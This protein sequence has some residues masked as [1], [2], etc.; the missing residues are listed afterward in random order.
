MIVYAVN[1]HTGGGKVL[2]DALIVDQPFG[3]ITK[4]YA[5]SRYVAP[6][7]KPAGVEVVAVKPTLYNRFFAEIK[8]YKDQGYSQA[9]EILFFGNLPPLFRPFFGLNKNKKFILYL[10]NAFLILSFSYPKNSF[11]ELV[12][13]SV[14]KLWLHLF[15]FNINEI[16]VQTPWMKAQT[17]LSLG[18]D[19]TIKVAPFLP[20]LPVTEKSTVKKYKFLYVGSLAKHKGLET[21]LKALQELDKKITTKISVCVVLDSASQNVDLGHFKNID[22]KLFTSANREDL[23]NIY[24]DSEYLVCTSRLESFYLPIYEAHHFGCAIILPANASYSANLPA[25]INAKTYTAPNLD[26]I[27]F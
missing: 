15:N 22:I 17:L 5:D 4:V 13:L 6:E 3:S 18:A 20:T 10:Q 2:L 16:W 27:G 14:E 19:K 7:N 23:F 12:R 1:I 9:N 21:F 26:L 8:M 24:K 25:S 11:K